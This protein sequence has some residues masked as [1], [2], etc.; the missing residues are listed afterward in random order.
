M[1]KYNEAC[2]EV[3]VIL[4]HLDEEEYSKIPSEVIEAIE[5]NKNKD[6]VF[7]FDE[8][9]ELRKQ[10]LLKET[11]AILFNIFRDYLCT[12][13]QRETIIQMQKEEQ[14]K[15]EERKKLQYS[16]DNLFKK[17]VCVSMM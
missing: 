17:N 8:E 9:V 13:S 1:S 2:S 7:E 10:K 12:Q 14:H 16:V 11:R 4:N 5:K 6:H 15:I 3:S